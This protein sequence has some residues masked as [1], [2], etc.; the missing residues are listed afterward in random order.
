[1]EPSVGLRQTAWHIDRYDTEPEHG[2]D[3]LY[4][5]IYDVK[6]D[7]STEFYRVYDIDTAG[8]DRL[9]HAVK[10]RNRL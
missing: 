5:A 10:T 1:M 2:R 8:S 4:R 3:N 7:A 9:K 6:V